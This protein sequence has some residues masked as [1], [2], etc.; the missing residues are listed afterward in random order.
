[1]ILRF[2]EDGLCRPST[3]P[4]LVNSA[5]WPKRFCSLSVNPVSLCSWKG[6]TLTCVVGKATV[7]SYGCPQVSELCYILVGW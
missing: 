5:F 1:M 7:I 6:N 3:D 4:E 2:G